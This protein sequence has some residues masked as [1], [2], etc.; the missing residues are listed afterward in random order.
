MQDDI[1]QM[2]QGQDQAP[3]SQA[4]ID[5]QGSDSGQGQQPTEQP[6]PEEIAFNNLPGS[7]KDRVRRL[8]QDKRDLIQQNQQ[9]QQQ[10]QQGSYVPPA[11]GSTYRTPEVETALQQL[12]NVGVTTDEKLNRTLDERLNALRWEQEMGRLEGKY[13]GRDGEPQFVREELEEFISSHPHYRSYAAEDVFRDHMFRSEFLNLTFN[14][15]GSKTGATQTLRPTNRMMSQTN[16]MTPEYIA[17]RTDINKY[18]DA[19]EWQ[20]EHRVEID[21]VLSQMHD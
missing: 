15:Q 13:P 9:L 6:T 8:V 5:G 12:A 7:T 21:K 3:A 16:A 10:M 2:L 1:N 11:P 19:V 20:E 18:P 4:T 14:K 17:E